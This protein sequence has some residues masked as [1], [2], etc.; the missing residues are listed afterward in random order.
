MLPDEPDRLVCDVAVIGA[1]IAGL[2]SSIYLRQAGL[3]VV[4]LDRQGYP[5][6]KVG[7]SLDWSSPWLLNTLGLSSEALLD[8]RIATPKAR[9]AVNEPGKDVWAAAPPPIIRR[10]PMRFETLTLHVDREALDRRIYERAVALGVDF[11]WERVANM[12]RAGDRLIACITSGGRRVEARW[13]I[14]ASGTGRFLARALDVPFVE[15]G[16]KKVCLWT[17]F[18]CEPLDAGTTFFLD[19][20]QPYLSWIWDIPITPQRTSVGLIV[21]ADSVQADRQRGLSPKEILTDAL[22][23][24]ERFAPA[25]AAQ[26]G[27]EV[28]ATSFQPYVTSRVCGPNW[29]MAGEAASMPDPLTGNGFTSGMRH[30]RWA[31]RVILR[32]GDRPE[33]APADRRWFSRHVHRLGRS[34]NSHIERV[35]YQAPV[36]RGLGMYLATI[37][38]TS[39]AFFMNALYT[40]FDPTGPMAMAIFDGV[41]VA[42]RGWVAAWIALGRVAD[43]LRPAR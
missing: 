28:Q 43:R 30:A 3:R 35:I 13:F 6:A 20:R 18:D 40:R 8:A 4:C 19:S 2:T 39:F 41:F 10:S 34:F 21:A 42:A 14:D 12:D 11:I 22:K 17:Y 27:F 38:Y 36:R 24:Y 1:G 33:L 31:T 9:I 29:L 7:E 25:L 15:Y 16:R 5:H 32:A 37:V 23:P 26:P